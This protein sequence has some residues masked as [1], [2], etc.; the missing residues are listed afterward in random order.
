MKELKREITLHLDEDSELYS[1]PNLEPS[2]YCLEVI[3]FNVLCFIVRSFSDY[4]LLGYYNVIQKLRRCSVAV[5]SCSIRIR[6][7]S[8]QVLAIS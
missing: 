6:H 2:I 1:N 5:L 3:E 4:T 8:K 7:L